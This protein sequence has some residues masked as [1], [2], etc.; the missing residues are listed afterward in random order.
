MEIRLLFDFRQSIT[1]WLEFAE[2]NKLALIERFSAL[3][4]TK[5]KKRERLKS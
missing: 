1:L 2:R 3:A 5:K 4:V